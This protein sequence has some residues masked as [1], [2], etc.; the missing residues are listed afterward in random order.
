MNYF[1][2]N[3]C[4]ESMH[5]FLRTED[6]PA[7]YHVNGDDTYTLCEVVEFGLAGR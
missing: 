4:P 7:A 2:S 5:V 6:G 3:T 1:D